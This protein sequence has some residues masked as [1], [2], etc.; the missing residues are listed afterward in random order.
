MISLKRKKKKFCGR[1]SVQEVSP[2]VKEEWVKYT[3]RRR[4]GQKF[5]PKITP[6]IF[7]RPCRPP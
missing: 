5:T 6:N 7:L 2:E 1:T 3:Q 4:D